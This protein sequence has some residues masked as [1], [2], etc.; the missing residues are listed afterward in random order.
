[1]KRIFEVTPPSVFGRPYVIYLLKHHGSYAPDGCKIGRRVLTR[2]S[3]VSGREQWTIKEV[4]LCKHVP[5]WDMMIDNVK[6]GAP[7]LFVGRVC[8]APRAALLWGEAEY[9]TSYVCC[10]FIFYLCFL[11]N[12]TVLYDRCSKVV[13]VNNFNISCCTT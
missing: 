12:D 2:F 7:K 3:G 8:T 10:R 9:K 5:W 13:Y 6:N 4:A 1:M 11:D